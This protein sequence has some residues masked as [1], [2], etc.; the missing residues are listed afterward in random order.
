MILSLTIA[1]CV[2]LAHGACLWSVLWPRFGGNVC[3][4][5][6]VKSIFVDT[7]GFASIIV[8]VHVCSGTFGV[9][10]EGRAFCSSS[11]FVDILVV[12]AVRI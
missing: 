5:V 12:V 7:C 6:V 4:G 10:V 8:S 2:H 9:A 1:T 11:Q 3:F